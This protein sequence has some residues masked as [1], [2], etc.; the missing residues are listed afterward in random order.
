M[1]TKTLPLIL[2]VGLVALVLFLVLEGLKGS[3][4]PEIAAP[5]IG[6]RPAAPAGGTTLSNAGGLEAADARVGAERTPEVAP[7]NGE[8]DEQLA[9]ADALVGRL[10]V[11]DEDGGAYPSETA[12]LTLY[13]RGGEGWLQVPVEDGLFSLAPVSATRLEVRSIQLQREQLGQ[14]RMARSEVEALP[15]HWEGEY[16]LRARLIAPVSLRVVGAD[17][18]QELGQVEVVRLRQ[19]AG[20]GWSHL[21]PGDEETV[22]RIG[23]AEA[24]PISLPA[25][26]GRHRYWAR[27]PGYAWGALDLDHDQGG[28]RTL[29]LQPESSMVVVLTGDPAPPGSLLR[30]RDPGRLKRSGEAR[31]GRVLLEARPA[32]D[33]PTRIAGLPPAPYLVSLEVEES[34]TILQWGRALATAAPHEQASVTLDLRQPTDPRV[35]LFGVLVLPEG[36]E[37]DSVR[38][39][40]LA[41][42]KRLPVDLRTEPFRGMESTFYWD[43]GRVLPGVH[44][45]WV[46]PSYFRQAVD[47]GPEGADVRIELPQR[48]L[49]RVRV[50]DS[51][52]REPVPGAEV[53]WK[54][55]TPE[56]L[57]RSEG[58]PVLNAPLDP[59]TGLF[60]VEVPAGRVVFEASAEGYL[61]GESEV[62][63]GADG[64]VV[65][66]DLDQLTAIRL[67][68]RDV[69]TGEVLHPMGCPR[70]EF[71]RGGREEPEAG[72]RVWTQSSGRTISLPIGDEY[73]LRFPEKD[74]VEPIPP[75][76]VVVGQGETVEVEVT[77]ELRKD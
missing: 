61:S 47:V 23:Q 18:E 62:L 38:M 40:V 27:S 1:R 9:P 67:V 24:S 21:L 19:S 68:Y 13:A 25:S 32:S 51:Q 3:R 49:A 76:T 2:A 10:T 57:G 22:E 52:T 73:T 48:V 44:V 30:L 4:E 64:P 53:T 5:S 42:N 6:P 63:I 33:G 65:D 34:G 46:Y 66:L 50:R 16:E 12:T 28:T 58:H 77:V 26:I 11:L 70:P 54:T 8:E 74:G 39:E 17:V 41:Q 35:E 60:L 75:M 7:A 15:T 71:E 69:E 36:V 43:A 14:A 20:T 59:D 31:V 29:E 55:P 45:I 37:R 56:L 72:N